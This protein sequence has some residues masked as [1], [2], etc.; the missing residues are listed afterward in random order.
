MKSNNSEERQQ[1]SDFESIEEALQVSVKTTVQNL[2]EMKQVSEIG[3]TFSL[4]DA[5]VKWDFEIHY[6]FDGQTKEYDFD[7]RIKSLNKIEQDLLADFFHEYISHKCEQY[8]FSNNFT[9]FMSVERP[10]F[11]IPNVVALLVFLRIEEPNPRGPGFYY[12]CLPL[13]N[14]EA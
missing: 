7:K 8:D 12:Q 4:F 10:I 6:I 11:Y 9:D 2:Q 14:P 1:Y 3:S 13:A 5:N